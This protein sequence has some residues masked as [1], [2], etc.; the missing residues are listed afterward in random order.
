[1]ARPYDADIWL[2]YGQFMAFLAPSFLKEK[3]EIDRWRVDGAKAILRAVDL[4]SDP[5]R[6]IAAATI[7]SNAGEGRAHLRILERQLALAD[8]P[9]TRQQLLLKIQKLEGTL[10]S[11]RAGNVVVHEWQTRFP[12][13]SRSATLLLGPRRSAPACAGPSSYSRKNCPR[14]WEMAVGDQ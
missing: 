9:E 7:L 6:S 14:D 12:F 11:E 4:G 1:L 10:D 8:N 13:M 3:A 2:H 5:E